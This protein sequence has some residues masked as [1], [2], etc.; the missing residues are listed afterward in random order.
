MRG[1]LP[2]SL[3][4][5]CPEDPYKLKTAHAQQ[6]QKIPLLPEEGSDRAAGGHA[7]HCE[8]RGVVGVTSKQNAHFNAHSFPRVG[9]RDRKSPGNRN[10]AT[11]RRHARGEAPPATQACSTHWVARATNVNSGTMTLHSDSV[12]SFF[13]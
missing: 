4:T 7:G 2:N 5:C 11:E 6:I 12:P 1:P 13:Q 3:L 8:G 10:P 9:M